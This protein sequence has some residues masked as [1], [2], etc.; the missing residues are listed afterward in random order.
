M[1]KHPSEYLEADPDKINDG[2]AQRAK[3]LYKKT[4][5]LITL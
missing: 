2:I 4:M 5:I 1:T 3:Q